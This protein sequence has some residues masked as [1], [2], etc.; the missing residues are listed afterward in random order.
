MNAARIPETATFEL[1]EPADGLDPPE[2]LL[3]SL[4]DT[5]A[6]PKYPT[7]RVVRRSMAVL[8][9]IPFHLV[10]LFNSDVPCD[11]ARLQELDKSLP[12]KPC[13]RPR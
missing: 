3:N 2:D 11:D 9:G 6:D 7:W 8:R 10:L 4:A 1:I 5:L 13:L 12:R